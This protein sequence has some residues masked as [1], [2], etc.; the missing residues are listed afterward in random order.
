MSSGMVDCWMMR[1]DWWMTTLV[2]WSS[3]FIFC[4]GRPISCNLVERLVWWFINIDS[5]VTIL[6]D[7]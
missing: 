5:V 6:V 2:A 3:T 7:N 4:I 1:G